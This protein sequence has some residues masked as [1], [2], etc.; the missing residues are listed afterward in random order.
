[1]PVSSFPLG[2]LPE[3]ANIS[4]MTARDDTARAEASDLDER[5]RLKQGAQDAR[6]AA[7]YRLAELSQPKP[8]P[9]PREPLARAKE[10]RPPEVTPPSAPSRQSA[11]ELPPEDWGGLSLL[12]IDFAEANIRRNFELA[13]ALLTARGLHEALERHEAF[14]AE[15]VKIYGEQA[16]E[17][18][19]LS[20]ATR[21]K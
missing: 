3:R 10:P 20:Q 19:E 7:A 14:M 1:M 12:L 4:S 18:R 16:A 17:L 2:R 9:G 8:L 6:R 13:R 11:R 15:S 21:V 5:A